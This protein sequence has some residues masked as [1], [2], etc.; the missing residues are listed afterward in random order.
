M[1]KL[2]E[3][4]KKLKSKIS[5]S[6]VNI[7][8]CVNCGADVYNSSSNIDSLCDDCSDKFNICKKCGRSL[9]GNI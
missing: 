6:V 4:C 7:T 9:N 2:C 3:G 8:K 1:G 5:M